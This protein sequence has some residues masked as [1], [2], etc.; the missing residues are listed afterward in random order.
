M[1]TVLS[2]DEGEQRPQSLPIDCIQGILDPHHAADAQRPESPLGLALPTAQACVGTDSNAFQILKWHET[3]V[4]KTA[5][6]EGCT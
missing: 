6:L 4:G 5:S 1:V 3:S 2:A